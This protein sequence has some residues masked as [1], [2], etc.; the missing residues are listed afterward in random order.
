MRWLSHIKRPPQR[1]FLTHGEE[2]VSN[3]LANTIRQQLRW[4]V[5]VPAYQETVEL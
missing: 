2:S 3:T 5:S 1:V 4:E